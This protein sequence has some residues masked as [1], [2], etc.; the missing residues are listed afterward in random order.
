MKKN[1][2]DNRTIGERCNSRQVWVI[3][4][5][6]KVVKNRKGKGSYNRQAT[7]TGSW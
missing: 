4:P 3:S 2:K 5:L 1:Q 7:K 6:T